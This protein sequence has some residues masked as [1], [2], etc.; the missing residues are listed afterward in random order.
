MTGNDAVTLGQ[1][2]RFEAKASE[3]AGVPGNDRIYI[4]KCYMT[5]SKDPNSEPKY[6]VIDKGG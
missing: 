5:S 1:M 6:T 3:G 4:M 2:M